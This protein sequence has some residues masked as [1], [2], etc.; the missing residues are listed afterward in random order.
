[1]PPHKYIDS[2]VGPFGGQ[3]RRTDRVFWR[4]GNVFF[5]STVSTPMVGEYE[6][7]RDETTPDTSSTPSVSD[8]AAAAIASLANETRLEVLFVLWDATD[9]PLQF[10]ELRRRVGIRDSGQFRYHLR[11]LEDQFVRRMPEGYDITSAG[12]N[13]VWAVRSGALNSGTD[14]GPFPLDRPCPACGA[15]LILRYED[16]VLAVTC[17]SCGANHGMLPFHPSGLVGR[18]VDEVQATYE[19]VLRTTLR[20]GAHDICPRCYGSGSFEIITGESDLPVD[21]RTELSAKDLTELTRYDPAAGNVNVLWSCSQ[22]GLWMDFQIG[23]LLGY[24]TE[25]AAFYRDHDV[26]FDS[27]PPWELFN[28]LGDLQVT[29]TETDPPSLQVFVSL[30]DA[31]CTVTLED[32]FSPEP[33]RGT[34]TRDFSPER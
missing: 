5:A 23:V 21:L 22:C 8:A 33:I 6:R 10:G 3:P 34:P 19:R 1:M 12:V 9:R 30:G 31:T 13:V 25:L 24:R 32:E 20:L 26:D 28:Y 11:K 29:V 17:D 14:V 27:I 7:G 2:D 15:T 16:L 4:L 18:T